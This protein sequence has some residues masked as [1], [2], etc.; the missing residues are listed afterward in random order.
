MKSQADGS[1][2]APRGHVR[3]IRPNDDL[4]LRP[5]PPLGLFSLIR[6]ERVGQGIGAKQAAATDGKQFA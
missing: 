6:F 3:R 5:I 2:N 1:S 4:V